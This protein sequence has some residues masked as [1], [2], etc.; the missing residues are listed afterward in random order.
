M[1]LNN[2]QGQLHRYYHQ[3]NHHLPCKRQER[4]RFLTSLKVNVNAYLEEHPDCTIEDILEQFGTVADTVEAYASPENT[5]HFM[6]KR[7][8]LQLIAIVLAVWL[9]AC[10][11]L[12]ACFIHIDRNTTVTVIEV[13]TALPVIPPLSQRIT[14]SL[15]KPLPA[16]PAARPPEILPP[17]KSF[18]G[19]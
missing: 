9:I 3:I 4:R 5:A 6:K 13:S 17:K 14:G 1:S 19:L 16:A 12:F 18:G 11:T 15:P 7:R 8:L 2:L 10:I